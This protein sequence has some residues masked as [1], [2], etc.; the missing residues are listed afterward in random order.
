MKKYKFIILGLI[1]VIAMLLRFY[2]LSSNPPSLTWDEAAWGYNAY[3][4]GIDGKDEFGRFLPVDY[5]ESFGDFKPVMYAYL[6]VI[7]IKIF[8]L[9]EFATRFPS[10][11]FG[12]L[13]VLLTYFL[14]KRIFSKSRNAELIALVSSLFLAVS[15]WHILLSRGAFEANV[16]SFFIV[17]GIWAFLSGVQDKKWYLIISAVSFALSMHTFNTSRIVAPLLVILLAIVFRK[18]LWQDKKQVFLSFIIGLLI[19]LPLIPFLLTP[20][21]S[22]RFKEVNIFSNPEIVKKANQQIENDNNALWS[23]LLNNRRVLYS[24]DFAKHYLDNLSPSFLFIKG[25]GNPKFSTQEVGQMYIWDIIFFVGGIFLLFRKREGNWWIIPL[26]ILIGILPAATARETPHALRIE[27]TLP[28]FQIIA[29]FGFVSVFEMINRYKKAVYGVLFALLFVNVAYFS[30]YYYAHYPKAYSGEWQFGYKQSVDYVKSVEKNY[31]YIQVTTALG[32]PYIY[33]LFYN[34]SSPEE[35]RN[36]SKI[37]REA[38]GF[39]K[40]E[41]VGKYLFPENYDYSRGSSSKV[42]YINTPYKLP[43]DITILKTFYLLNGVPALVAYTR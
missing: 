19:L 27:T 12:V 25:D 9:N 21:A 17:L 42:L 5:F 10:A 30:H 13:T 29:A 22:L 7:P 11:F 33:Y 1:I 43:E 20:Q 35:F 14:V 24:L 39:V 37:K 15:P 32:R 36:S 26:W 3:S 41:K 4:L 18:V 40:V 6:D 38:F 34:K 2:Q 8:G 16:A 28:A 23:K 31:D